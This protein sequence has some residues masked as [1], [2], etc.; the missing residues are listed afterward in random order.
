[1]SIVSVKCKAC[2]DKHHDHYA[3]SSCGAVFGF[4]FPVVQRHW[5]MKRLR[6]KYCPICGAKAK[7]A[8]SKP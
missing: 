6:W 1:M 2:K 5:G 7:G 8:G 3:C 4:T